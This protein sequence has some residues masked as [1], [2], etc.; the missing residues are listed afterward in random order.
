MLVAVRGRC[1]ILLLYQRTARLVR[2]RGQV[3]A[4]D[5]PTFRLLGRTYSQLPCKHA[6]VWGVVACCW[7]LSA[8]A[9]AVAVAVI[10]A[11]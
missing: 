11:C 2:R 3:R 4:T 9:V 8:A 6:C 7:L 1:C 5:P 10:S